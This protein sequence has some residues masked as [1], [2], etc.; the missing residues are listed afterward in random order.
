MF[1]LDK[2]RRAM[3]QALVHSWL[4]QFLAGLDTKTDMNL[5]ALQTPGTKAAPTAFV[6]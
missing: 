3:V 6:P 1:F 4:G 2:T 5:V